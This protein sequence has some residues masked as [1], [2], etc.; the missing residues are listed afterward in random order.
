MG[1]LAAWVYFVSCA[2]RFSG[3][4]FFLVEHVIIIN[5]LIP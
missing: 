4:K 5:V 2:E 1:D 3:I